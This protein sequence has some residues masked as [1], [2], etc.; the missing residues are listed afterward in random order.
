[1]YSWYSIT[2]R[3][4][5]YLIESD[6]ASVLKSKEL[7]NIELTSLLS[8][9]FFLLN[10]PLYTYTYRCRHILNFLIYIYIPF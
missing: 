9:M 2:Q 3:E 1:M 8:F 4:R 5:F 10:F 6:A 7:K